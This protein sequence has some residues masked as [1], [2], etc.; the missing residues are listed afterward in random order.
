M[1]LSTPPRAPISAPPSARTPKTLEPGRYDPFPD[2]LEELVEHVG[3]TLPGRMH[4]YWSAALS[5]I[6]KVVYK[7]RPGGAPRASRPPTRKSSRSTGASRTRGGSTS[8]MR[9][10]AGRT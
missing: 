8:S 7:S 9:G 3:N 5:S 1:A 4:D 6:N 2:P 10:R